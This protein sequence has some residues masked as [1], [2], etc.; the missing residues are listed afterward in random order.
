LPAF[1]IKAK[2]MSIESRLSRF[3]GHDAFFGSNTL[4]NWTNEVKDPQFTLLDLQKKLDELD[5]A[6][7][8]RAKQSNSSAG[9]AKKKSGISLL[10][11]FYHGANDLNTIIS[12][13][14]KLMKEYNSTSQKYLPEVNK[15]QL[16]RYNFKPRKWYFKLNPFAGPDLLLLRM[17][18][19]DG[20]KDA[21]IMAENALAQKPAI[22]SQIDQILNSKEKS[23]FLA[24]ILNKIQAFRFQR[25]IKVIDKSSQVLN[26]VPPLPKKEFKQQLGDLTQ[27]YNTRFPG[28]P[29]AEVGKAIKAGSIG[30]VFEAK[31]Q[32]GKKLV[33]KV[34]KPEITPAYLDEYRRFL[35]FRQLIISG[36]TE[37]TRAMAAEHVNNTVH[38]LKMETQ[39]KQEAIN[40]RLMK[41]AV[42]GL[43]LKG[44]TVPD[45]LAATK[46]GM[47]LPFVGEKDFQEL[48]NLESG[49]KY[50]H[51]IAPDLLRLLTFSNVK[52]LDIHSGNIRVG[53]D[54]AYLIDHGRQVT[55]KDDV[56]KALLG[57]TSAVYASPLGK[58]LAS[59]RAIRDQLAALYQLNPK[60]DNEYTQALNKLS[61]LD[62]A[63]D[64]AAKNKLTQDLSLELKK[65][66]TLL[67]Q[68]FQTAQGYKGLMA[69]DPASLNKFLKSMNREKNH[70]DANNVSLL[71]LWT[72]YANQSKRLGLP[73]LS[74]Q[75]LSPKD[76]DRYQQK[77]SKFL[78]PYFQSKIN[79][80]AYDTLAADLK[81]EKLEDLFS[82]AD[83]ALQPD[84]QAG[85][86]GVNAAQSP[87]LLKHKIEMRLSVDWMKE[88]MLQVYG[89]H[90]KVAAVSKQLTSDL[91][92]VSG[93]TLTEA[94]NKVLNENL[95]ASIRNDFD[96]TSLKDLLNPVDYTRRLNEDVK[97]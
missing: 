40:T 20:I 7:S 65:M 27:A 61:A 84:S 63:P 57:L 80:K 47:V 11:S 67:V 38:L 22:E 78:A 25:A 51:Q 23:G 39:S 8:E 85:S 58:N 6:Q 92:T 76:L 4:P 66:D 30:Q 49:M 59:N 73:D 90:R 48:N 15:K 52:P 34:V 91:S 1:G 35:Y 13:S 36:A 60:V 12:Y 16:F 18:G 46:H 56:N 24:S 43:S 45:V 96:L 88:S 42:E 41:E 97:K 70:L 75:P 83:I 5:K 26:N 89:E 50:R 33:F 94:Q 14:T 62:E 77:A 72:N 21:Q 95:Q 9:E 19:P 17:L 29:V 69:N 31:T 44:F 54:Q 79:A 87:N 3:G 93:Q 71:N 74:E 32:S 64:E 10:T 28:D 86:S 2:G 81:N 55:L 68:L 53:G 37:Q 82:A